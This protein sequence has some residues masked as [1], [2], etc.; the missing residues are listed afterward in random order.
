MEEAESRALDSFCLLTIFNVPGIYC[1]VK[2]V[3][4]N[5][6]DCSVVNGVSGGLYAFIIRRGKIVRDKASKP[7][8]TNI[9]VSLVS[10]NMV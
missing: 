5:Q 9:T 6:F 3:M 4:C 2:G 8:K 10:L 1:A 7:R